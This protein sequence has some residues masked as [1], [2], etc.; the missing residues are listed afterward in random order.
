[1]MRSVAAR[2]NYR[3]SS[4]RRF[5]H[6]AGTTRK[7]RPPKQEHH[8]CIASYRIVSHRIETT[9]HSITFHQRINIYHCCCRRRRRRRR[10]SQ[11]CLRSMST[12][13]IGGNDDDEKM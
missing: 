11:S 8:H 12:T 10:Q 2:E 13:T 6:M 9:Q 5:D 7:K 1:M 3:P 4:G